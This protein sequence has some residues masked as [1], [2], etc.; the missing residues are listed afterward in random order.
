MQIDEILAWGG[1]VAAAWQNHDIDGALEIFDQCSEYRETPFAENAA[2][3]LDGIRSLWREIETQKCISVSCS[4]LL[5]NSTSA[6]YRYDSKYTV[7]LVSYQTSGIWYVRFRGGK[8]VSF[9]QWS[10]SDS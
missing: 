1:K 4:V 9:Q 8:C 3:K 6:V 10:S 7:G 5:H 2:L